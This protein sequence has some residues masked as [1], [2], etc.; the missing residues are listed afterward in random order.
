MKKIVLLLILASI[1]AC[2]SLMEDRD[3]RLTTASDG[4]LGEVAAPAVEMDIPPVVQQA[5]I[6]AAPEPAEP[7]QTFTVVAT[8]LPASELLFALA[9]DARLNLD[10]D[11]AID[12]RVSINAIDQTLPQILKRI[13]RQ[14]SLHYYLDGPNLVVEVDRPFTRVYRIDYLN[15]SRSTTSSVGI[16]TA[17]ASGGEGSSGDSSTTVTNASSNDFWASLEANL[18]LLA[19]RNGETG[20]IIS[21]RESGTISINASS[22]AHQDIQRFVDQVTRSARQQVLIEA[23][24]VEVTLNDDFQ[25]GVDWSRIANGDGWSLGQDLLSSTTTLPALATGG[26]VVEASYLNTNS[27]RDITGA[28]RA[29]DAFG[30]VSVM[31]SP[32]IMA[33]NNQTSVLKVADNRVYFEIDATSNT[34]TGTN[35]VVTQTFNTTLKT[36]PVGFVM[37]VTPFITENNEV[38][39]NIRPTIT[40]ILRFVNDPNPTLAAAGVV[41]PIPEIQVREMES[42]LRV[43][44][45]NTAVIGGLMQD[46]SDSSDTGVPGLHDVKGVGV[47]FGTKTRSFSKTELVIFLRPRVLDNASLDTG[48]QDF[49]RYLKPEKF[50]GE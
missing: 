12:G 38:I 31:S 1:S 9:R 13:S 47:L 40:R 41:S 10:I 32:K 17:L 5:P 50:N 16:E 37:N 39:L 21:N 35:S 2:A 48:L 11:P 23:T 22:A 7:L 19:N 46:T 6:I 4:H 26:P 29:L 14:V 8:D 15:M 36:V 3:E 33:L 43:S 18:Q 45:G 24:V 49:K 27:E 20:V 34:T 25:A 30:D 28:I 42:V 44:S